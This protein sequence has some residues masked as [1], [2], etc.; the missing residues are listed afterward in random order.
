MADTKLNL[1]IDVKGASKASAE[2]KKVEEAVTK[3]SGKFTNLAKTSKKAKVALA[4]VTAAGVGLIGKLG[5]MAGNFEQTEVA[6]TTML[7]SAEDAQAL[8]ADIAQFAASTPFEL[9]GIQ[10]AAKSLLAFGT[11]TEDIIPTLRRLGDVGA[12]LNIPLGELS[13]IYGKAQ[14]SG[15]LF[16]ED[17]NQLSGRGIPI[18]AELAKQFGVAESEVRGLVESGAVGFENLEEAFVSMT[19]EGGQFAGLMEAQSETLLGQWS[20]LQDALTQLGITLGTALLPI[21]KPMVE[22]LAAMANRIKEFAEENPRV[23]KLVGIL[24]VATTAI[25]AILVPVTALAAALPMLAAGW[26]TVSASILPVTAVIAAVVAAVVLLKKAWDSNFMG[27]QDTTKT[28]ITIAK[29]YFELFKY[30]VTTIFNEIKDFIQTVMELEFI[31]FIRNALERLSGI[32]DAAWAK[33]R[34]FFVLVWD[35]IKNTVSTVWSIVQNI[36]I[37]GMALLNGD[38]E[39]AWTK[40][41]EVLE[42]IWEAIVSSITG[43]VD[44][45][46]SIIDGFIGSIK[47]AIDWLKKLIKKDEEANSGI[48]SAVEGARAIGGGVMAGNSYLVGERG[49]EIF[50]PSSTGTI[51]PNHR[52]GGGNNIVINIS[53]VIN[54]DAAEAVAEMTVK[55]LQLSS[56]IG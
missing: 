8:L 18:I 14:T 23:A 7:G 21:L 55:Q 33:I 39:L 13:E 6:F 22:T 52:M 35:R 34:D 49:P 44:T 32:W 26:A 28:F 46:M 24:V 42:T 54:D 31:E 15:R 25:A 37:G 53:G 38:W 27:I 10:S 19:D 45:V 41:K 16:A 9:P 20:N 36:V 51:T 17:I 4:A 30:T 40:V 12:G 47:S 56:V 43:Y 11:E 2:V 5:Q 1:Q 3:T 48:G 29:F 50:T